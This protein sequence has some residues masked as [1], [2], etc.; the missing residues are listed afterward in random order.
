MRRL[1]NVKHKASPANNS[2]YQFA[3]VNFILIQFIFQRAFIASDKERWNEEQQQEIRERNM[4]NVVVKHVL[5]TYLGRS[6]NS[7]PITISI[8]IECGAPSS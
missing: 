7:S 3:M 2:A 6:P 8:N 5:N 1:I 4:M